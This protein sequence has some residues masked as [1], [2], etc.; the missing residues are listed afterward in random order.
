MKNKIITIILNEYFQRIITLLFGVFIGF[1]FFQAITEHHISS[2]YKNDIHSLLYLNFL[3]T[4]PVIAFIG[5]TFIDYSENNFFQYFIFSLFVFTSILSF[6]YFIL[7]FLLIILFYTI[8]PLLLSSL[9]FI[10]SLFY[11]KKLYKHLLS[12]Q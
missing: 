7:S 9:I 12:V 11:L 2:G 4:I 10:G 8:Y 6:I 5:V 3:A 1:E